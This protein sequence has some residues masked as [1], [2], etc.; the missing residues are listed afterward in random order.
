MARHATAQDPDYANAHCIH[1]VAP[2]HLNRIKDAVIAFER[3]VAL[4]PDYTNAPYNLGSA[5][6][7]LK[8]YFEAERAYR[9]A[10]AVDENY[11]QAQ[12]A[13]HD[14]APLRCRQEVQDGIDAFPAAT[15]RAPNDGLTASQL[16]F[17]KRHACD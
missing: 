9:G 14:K 3:A 16:Y 6:H 8:K 7:R 11:A 10:L 1:G 12:T 15:D 4:K 2:F 5:L 17:E 13:G